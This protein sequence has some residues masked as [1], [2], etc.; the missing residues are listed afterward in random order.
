[1]QRAALFE[2]L[3]SAIPADSLW[4]QRLMRRLACAFGSFEGEGARATLPPAP[5]S[6]V[7]ITWPTLIFSP[8]FTR[9]SFTTP[10]TVDGTST[11]ALSVSSSITAW[12]S[13]MAAPGEIISRTKSPWSMFSPSSGSLNSVTV[14]FSPLLV[15]RLGRL[16]WGRLAR[17]AEGKT[18]SGRRQD[19]GALSD[20]RVRFLRIDAQ[21]FDCLLQRA[22]VYLFVPGQCVQRS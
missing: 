9:I 6:K 8:S 17:T 18:R 14:T 22:S 3:P 4:W 19:A 7:K 5:F 15:A 2:P 10:L 13:V 21:I 12:P 11:T 16:S 20:C 1:M